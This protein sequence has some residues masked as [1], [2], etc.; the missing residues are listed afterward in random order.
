MTAIVLGAGH[1]LSEQF[2]ENGVGYELV[3]SSSVKALTGG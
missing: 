1:D 3:M 2:E